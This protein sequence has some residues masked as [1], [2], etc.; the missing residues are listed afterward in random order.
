MVRVNI[1]NP[2]FL[3]DQH[4]IAEYN[5]LL[6]LVA[7]IR[8]FPKKEGIPLRYCLGKGHMKFFKDKLGYLKKRHELLKKEM[9]IRGFKA[10]KSLGK[11]NSKDWKASSKDKEI[12]KKRIIEKIKLKPGF[13]R[14][15]GKNR[16]RRFLIELVK[17]A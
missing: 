17:K 1:I 6:M 9:K 7:Y 12:I 4:L 14:Y 13:Y 2:R 3:T 8:K 5:E 16:S 11:V 10:R 15:Y